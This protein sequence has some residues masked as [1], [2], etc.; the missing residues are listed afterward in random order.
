M[1]SPTSPASPAVLGFPQGAEGRQLVGGKLRQ[2]GREEI[3]VLELGA[4]G[5]RDG[6][7]RRVG[8]GACQ[9]CG[10]GVCVD[11]PRGSGRPPRTRARRPG[12]R[13]SVQAH[14][15]CYARARARRDGRGAAAIRGAV[16]GPCPHPR[17]QAYTPTARPGD[18]GIP[19]RGSGSSSALHSAEG[20]DACIIP[21]APRDRPRPGKARG[22]RGE[23]ARRVP[24]TW[25]RPRRRRRVEVDT[26]PAEELVQAVKQ[27]HG[28]EAVR[29][30]RSQARSQEQGV[31]PARAGLAER[32]GFLRLDSL[33]L[34]L[35]KAKNDGKR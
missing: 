34:E 4:A 6:D 3:S 1:P 32:G 24:G 19:A 23:C 27:G 14:V 18:R 31:V 26:R 9:C 35:G 13:G 15:A 30:I 28:D 17:P 29:K 7:D 20:A 11:D 5:A 25:G 22:R 33:S 10:A 2:R 16:C 21:L 12:G 8:H